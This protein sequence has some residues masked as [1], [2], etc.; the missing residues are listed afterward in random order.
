MPS[1]KNL[2]VIFN[3]YKFVLK[4]LKDKDV[5]EVGCGPGLGSKII[6]ENCNSY[7]GVDNNLK[8]IETAKKNNTHIKNN[9]KNLNAYDIPSLNLKFDVIICLATIYY[10]DINRFIEISK[11][12][13]NKNGILIFDMSNKNIPNFDSKWD[14]QTDYYQIEELKNIMLRNKIDHYEVY[15]SIPINRKLLSTIIRK[16]RRYL[17]NI[18][19]FLGL[20]KFREFLVYLI[21]KQYHAPPNNINDLNIDDKNEYVR[22]ENDKNNYDY[23]VFFVKAN[24]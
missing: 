23:N 13:L 7:I 1:K 22:L 3:R 5:L 11:K 6:K 10:L 17:R 18:L 4:Y 9:F 12:V 24:L 20:N 2:E 19:I 8:N 21:D 15:G 14:G 16:T